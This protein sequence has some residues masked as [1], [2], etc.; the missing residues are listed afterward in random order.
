MPN[1]VDILRAR[2]RRRSRRRPLRLL[3][4]VGKLLATFLALMVGAAGLAGALAFAD[5]RRDLPSA[6]AIEVLFDPGPGGTYRTTQYYDRTGQV[7]LSEIANPAG[8]GHRGLPIDLASPRHLPESL[9]Q[10]TVAFEDPGFWTEPG[11]DLEWLVRAVAEALRGQAVLTGGS[12]G[13]R[14]ALS[15][16]IPPG[17]QHRPALLRTL[18]TALLA[19]EVIRRYSREQVLEWYLNSADFGHQAYGAD[20]AALVYFSKHAELL[21]LAESALLAGIL[22]QPSLNPID[23]PQQAKARQALVLEAMV[24]QGMISAAEAA[25]AL[26]E[27]L[28][29]R[30]P[31]TPE[32]Q[33]ASEFA[34]YAGRQLAEILGSA[35]AGRGGLRVITT[36]DDD[37]Q[38]QAECVVQ[39]QMSRLSGGE[40]GAVIPAA[41]GSA[42]VA[43]SLLSP[44]RPSDAGLDHTLSAAAAVVIDPT[45]GEVL[46]LVGLEDAGVGADGGVVLAIDASR[47]SGPTLY[48][49]IYLTAF[50]SGYTPATMVLD[51]PTV[52][53]DPEGGAAFTPLNGDGQFHGP[54]RMRTA[55]ANAYAVPAARTLSLMGVENALRTAHQMGVS[56]LDASGAAVSVEVALG[57]GEASLLDLTYAYGVIAAGGRMAGVPT[58][59]EEQRPE[60]RDLDPVA[61]LRVEDA[62]GRVIYQ[63]SSEGRAVL[64]PQLAYLMADVLRDEPARW[65]AF[66]HPNPLEIGRPAGAVAG[67][68]GEGSDSWALGFTPSRAV[69]VWLGN[70]D[71]E[72]MVG[73]GPANGA[74]PIWN[75]LVRYATRDLPAEGWLQPAGVSQVEVCDP[76]G[77]LPTEYCPNLVR[78][79]FVQGTEPTHYDTLYQP[80]RINR[81][82]GKLATLFTPL[83]LIEERVYLM[84]PPEAAE[85]ARLAGIGRPPQEYDTIYQPA[86][87]PD[88]NLAS[89]ESFAMLRGEVEVRGDARP[90]GF[91]YFRLQYGQG[92]N[93]T[94]WVQIGE[95][96][97]RRVR[98]GVLGRWDTSGLNGL[99]TL[100]LLVVREEGRVATA[101]VP[102]TVDNLPPTIR[103]VSPEED[104]VFTWPADQEAVLQAEV[105]DDIQLARVEFYVDSR[106]VATAT[107]PPYSTRWSLGVPGEHVFFV[108][109][110]DAAGNRAESER[111]T[112]TVRR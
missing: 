112:I 35:F 64:S 3:G 45:T 107:A 89:P 49:F 12:I 74:A 65:P 2:Q 91:E 61:I 44:L 4:E 9:V 34:R 95:D 17:E 22:P 102:V 106:G 100:Q 10:A 24:R 90:E 94:R 109:A 30:P 99:Y 92:L 38:L 63:A 55:L 69:G 27:P 14:L 97:D 47:P 52:F 96:A 79:V 39:T 71:G 87:D 26:A 104:Q 62:S 103:L 77:L 105:S 93:P 8:A 60:F 66:G 101:A 88:V 20:A 40:P 108:R 78:E 33:S 42:C 83:D 98:A 59:G 46:S 13:Q 15:T 18:R 80:F 70:P 31:Q 11:Y 84:P 32:T 6:E 25:A 111:L 36:L 23:A 41:D 54:I 43:A 50:A 81:E 72:P 110:Y 53:G 19:S 37:L 82:T 58:P 85:W 1:A 68:A 29:L 73:M 56:T 76:S 51:I 28:Q 75:A 57:G 16:L 7:L 48:P 21:S 67:T 86:Y 5:V